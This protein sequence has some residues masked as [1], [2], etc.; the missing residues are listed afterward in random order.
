M[1]RWLA[2][3]VPE[4]V[5]G[6]LFLIVLPALV[7]L[8]QALVHKW[9][10]Q[11]RRGEHND[12]AGIILGASAVAYSVAIGLCV[13][14]MWDKYDEAKEAIEAEAMNLGALADGSGVFEA[15]V[16]RRIQEG[17]IAYNRDAVEQW[18]GRTRGEASVTSSRDLALLHETVG[19]LRP[20]SHAQ[21][22]FVDDAVARLASAV[23]LR[24]TSL[25]LARDEQLPDVL[26]IAV[27]GGSAIVLG[28]CLTTG[29]PDSA[30]RRVLIFGLAA[31]VGINLFLVVELNY[32]FHGEFA[33]RPDS[34]TE[35]TTSIER[36][37]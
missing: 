26:W 30:L 13:V 9:A 17:V 16:Q 20:E 14:T 21:R 33:I 7:V 10:P 18:A 5:V 25:R 32:P 28:L 11:W 31:I 2:S 34:F 4:W 6:V 8:S 19:Q 35:V 36:D 3:D 15:P 12:A 1:A 23:E 37:S 24:A 27:L 22:A 29:I